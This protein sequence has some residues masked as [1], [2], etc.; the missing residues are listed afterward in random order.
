MTK[1]KSAKTTTLEIENKQ[2]ANLLANIRQKILDAAME[3][4]AAVK[5]KDLT[6]FDK[7]P[8]N[9]KFILIAGRC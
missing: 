7:I 9:F 6:V 5:I 1:R 2:E 3:Q 4:I 8:G